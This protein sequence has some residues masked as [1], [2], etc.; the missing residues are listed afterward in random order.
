MSIQSHKPSYVLGES[1]HAE[2]RLELLSELTCPGFIK[3][4]EMV[5]KEN[6]RILIIGCGSGHLEAKLSTIFSN[7]HFVGIDIS[8]KRIEEARART[9]RLTCTNTYELIHADLTILS[10]KDPKPFDILISRF[11]LSHLANPLNQ[12]NRFLPLIKPMGFVCFEEIASDGS[13]YFCNTKN[14]G[15][16]SFIKMIKLQI[17]AQQSS[18]D[19]GFQ[20]LSTFTKSRSKVLHCHLAQAILK[21]ARHKS[22]LRLGL[23]DAQTSLFKHLDQKAIDSTI[24]SLREFEEDELSFGL[25]AR[26]LTATIQLKP[27]KPG[28]ECPIFLSKF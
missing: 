26:T 19:T 24:N 21:N 7:S 14:P 2:F 23:E 3:A 8:E 9:A 11:V 27:T 18:F 17:Q 4:M 22:I 16:Q 20:L 5:P 25:Y 6:V 15:Y 10:F 28:Y 13:E 12:L 1:A